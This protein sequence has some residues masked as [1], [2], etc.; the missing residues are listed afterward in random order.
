MSAIYVKKILLLV[1]LLS[2]FEYHQIRVLTSDTVKSEYV[3]K[4]LGGGDSG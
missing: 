3:H 1:T 4:L 2:V